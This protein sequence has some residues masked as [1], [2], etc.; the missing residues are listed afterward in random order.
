MSIRFIILILIIIII[1]AALSLIVDIGKLYPI[2]LLVSNIIGLLI[3]LKKEHTREQQEKMENFEYSHIVPDNRTDEEKRIDLLNQT[4]KG[5]ERAQYAYGDFHKD[6]DFEIYKSFRDKEPFYEG[7]DP[8]ILDL[9]SKEPKPTA[10]GL[11]IDHHGYNEK[12]LEYQSWAQHNVYRGMQGYLDKTADYY[13]YFFK[14]E[15]ERE[16]DREWWQT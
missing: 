5:G 16:E 13:A 10:G 15:F 3:L 4:D 1:V 6:H 9:Y 8:M 14:D 7:P 11:Y 2:I 12:A